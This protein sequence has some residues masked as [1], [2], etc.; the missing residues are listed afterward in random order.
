MYVSTSCPETLAKS[1][2]HPPLSPPPSS[3]SRIDTVR[4]RAAPS[5]RCARAVFLS[6]LRA[7]LTTTCDVYCHNKNNGERNPGMAQLLQRVAA[8]APEGGDR[9]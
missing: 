8:K 6:G 4:V 7:C 2:L 9:F 3:A 1:P 5:P